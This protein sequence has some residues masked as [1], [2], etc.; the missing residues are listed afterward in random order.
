MFSPLLKYKNIF[1]TDSIT[2]SYFDFAFFL[3][4]RG[5]KQ[6]D[7]VMTRSPLYFLLNLY[8]EQG[9][10]AK[11]SIISKRHNLCIKNNITL[12]SRKKIWG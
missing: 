3:N 12:F 10:N 9:H 11:L 8:W 1:K 2:S 6:I 5:K 4:N 7:L